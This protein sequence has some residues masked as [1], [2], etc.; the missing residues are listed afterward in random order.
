MGQYFSLSY[1]FP[2]KNEEEIGEEI[3]G[4]EEIEGIEELVKNPLSAEKLLERDEETM[5]RLCC[6]LQHRRFVV[7]RLS[8]E[9]E[10]Q[11][12]TTRH[13]VEQ[14]FAQPLEEKLKYELPPSSDPLLPRKRNRGPF[15]ISPSSPLPSSPSPSLPLP[16]PLLLLYFIS[17]IYLLFNDVTSSF[18]LVYVRQK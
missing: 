18:H 4:R 3:E 13:L 5:K 15:F 2:N 1:Y 6:A 11:I 12:I 8:E 7:I 9:D 17:F 14:F 10:Q 16:F